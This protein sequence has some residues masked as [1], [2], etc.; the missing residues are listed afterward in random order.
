M[1]ASSTGPMAEIIAERLT[2]ALS[3]R[4]LDVVNDSARHAG[5]GG[6]DG[7]GESHFSVTIVADA[8]TG[9]SRV[10]RQRMV[11]RALGTLMEKRIH[12]LSIRA[13]APEEAGIGA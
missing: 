2:A 7:S 4:A 6:H 10:E 12:A 8:F 1:T 3:P 9:A 13:M 5:H 11:N